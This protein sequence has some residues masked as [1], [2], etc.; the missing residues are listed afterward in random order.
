MTAYLAAVLVGAVL[1]V[2]VT[3]YWN[4]DDILGKMDRDNGANEYRKGLEAYLDENLEDAKKFLKAAVTKNPANIPAYLYL[5]R[6]YLKEGTEESALRVFNLARIQRDISK[7]NKLSTLHNM[8]RL[9]TRK[10]EYP[11]AIEIYKELIGEDR[12]NVDYYRELAEIYVK[13]EAWDKA[14]SYEKELMKRTRSDDQ[15]FLSYILTQK[16]N[17]HLAKKENKEAIKSLKQAISLTPTFIYPAQ[18][19]GDYYYNSGD[20]NKAVAEWE[21]V[22]LKNKYHAFHIYTRLEKA[23]F[24]LGDF[25]RINAIYQDVL[26]VYPESGET[27]FALGRIYA[28]KGQTKEFAGK[29]FEASRYMIPEDF[30]KIYRELLLYRSGEDH[31]QVSRSDLQG[32]LKRMDK[33]DR[34]YLCGHCHRLSSEFTWRCPHC[35]EWESL[36]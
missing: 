34:D 9:N 7:T 29:M 12:S 32:I 6:I 5:G 1:A 15:H 22:I 21:R 8:A 24:E 17:S 28:K 25:D 2:I 14:Y 26:K 16:A 11:Q 31:P 18:I 13:N 3:R 33:N 35:G 30:P 36:H 20:I 4:P 19:L 10:K 23:L 27:H